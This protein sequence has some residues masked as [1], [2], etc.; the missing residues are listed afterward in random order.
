MLNV[1]EYERVYT[2]PPGSYS[3]SDFTGRLALKLVRKEGNARFFSSTIAH[4]GCVLWLAEPLQSI[5]EDHKSAFLAGKASGD[6]FHSLMNQFLG[7]VASFVAGQPLDTVKDRI[8]A[9]VS[10]LKR[11]NLVSHLILTDM[12]RF[13]CAFGLISPTPILISCHFIPNFFL[14]TIANQ[15]TRGRTKRSE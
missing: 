5:V 4:V 1:T 8:Q 11:R 10:L 7:I 6:L 14:A 12:V 2:D 15:S 9:H 13:S 3:C